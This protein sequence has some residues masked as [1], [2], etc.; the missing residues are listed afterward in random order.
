MPSKTSRTRLALLILCCAIWATALTGAP[1]IAGQAV[2][3]NTVLDE[4]DRQMLDLMNG[5]RAAA[6]A[7]S[8]TAA[9]GLRGLALS[10]SHNMAN[11]GT[12]GVLAHNPNVRT[13]LPSFGAANATAWAENVASWSP[14]DGRNAA[15]V[16]AL[17]MNSPG[18][19]ANILNP[20]MRYVGIGSV[21]SSGN[22]G[23]NTQNFTNNVDPVAAPVAP[24]GS[25][26]T[27][28]LVGS[29]V[30]VAGWALDPSSRGLSIPVHVY[31]NNA[32]YALSTSVA[33]PDV[34]AA[35]GASGTHGFVA[36]LDVP[37]GSSVVC[38]YAISATGGG[39]PRLGCVTV[40]RP[41]AVAPIGSFDTAT[42]VGST[43]RV[44]GWA[45]DPSSRG[46]SIPV[47]VYVNNAGYALSTSVARPDVN[48]AFGASGTHGFV[49]RLPVPAGV[50]TVCAY[51]IS[52]TGG[53]NT[54]IGCLR[55]QRS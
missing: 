24:I 40:V 37:V 41:A 33:R 10:W 45:L 16:F 8:L 14:G 35:F 18:H 2:A 12:G 29:T 1:A 48:A 4:F 15:S 17:Y 43:V 9:T 54:G 23:Y 19:K 55:V 3:A 27:A 20:T 13:Q 38:A 47:H 36:A 49:D 21:I 52:T 28:T 50:S 44:A 51:A 31:V 32:G 30:R 42:V 26:D 53:G 46:L 39:N 22:V 11:G 5:A 7:P 6:G 25:F 34:N